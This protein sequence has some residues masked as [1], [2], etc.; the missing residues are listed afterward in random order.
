MEDIVG[1]R[2]T[3]TI[4]SWFFLTGGIWKLFDRVEKATSKDAKLAA[5]EWL[6]SINLSGL[7][8]WPDSFSR[9]FDSIFG[10]NHLTFR[11]FLKSSIASLL[12]VII[13]TA[14]WAAIRPLEFQKFIVHSDRNMSVFMLFGFS[15]LVNV[16]PDYISLFET[17]Y[18]LRF[19]SVSPSLGRQL[20][21]LI[22]DALITAVIALGV[23]FLFDLMM[24][25]SLKG[26]I[27]YIP[28]YILP[29]KADYSGYFSPGIWFYS[30]FLTSIWIWLYLLSGISVI[31]AK[32]L[33]LVLIAARRVLDV[34]NKP[35]VSL[36]VIAIMG[37]TV[38]Y[39]VVF[40]VKLLF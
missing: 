14:I 29:L 12:A 6:N 24:D 35:F 28:L 9:A 32:K 21:L 16:L 19:L 23:W 7:S 13:C 5:S 38:V 20:L 18:V 31:V 17:R 39:I 4:G 22:I 36:G 10:S 27:E 33:N 11:C 34:D 15:L 37:V 8:K 25:Y 1:L 3:L 26:T 2:T 40:T 30:T